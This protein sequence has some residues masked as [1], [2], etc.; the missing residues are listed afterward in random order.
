[1]PLAYDIEAYF[2][3][4][5]PRIESEPYSAPETAGGLSN[6]NTSVGFVFDCSDDRSYRLLIDLLNKGYEVR[7]ARRAFEN[8]GVVYN[9]GSF[10]V[11][12]NDNPDLDVEEL[13]QLAEDAGVEVDGIETSLGNKLADLGGGEFAL[14]ERPRIA[15][16][17]GYPVS[18]SS[19][20]AT[21]HLLD[22]RF[23]TRTSLLE[24]AALG[25]ADLDKYNVL[26]LPDNRGGAQSYKT[27]LGKNGLNRLKRWVESGGTLIGIGTGAAFMADSSA[28]LTRVRQKRQSLKKL[29]VFDAALAAARNAEHPEVDSLDVWEGKPESGLEPDAPEVKAPSPEFVILKEKDERARRLFPRGAILTV[30]LDEEHW[31]TTGCRNRVPVLFNSRYALIAGGGIE[32]PGRLAG[33]DHLRLSGLLWPEAKERWAETVYLSREARGRGQ[34]ILFAATPNFRGYFYGAE[35]LLLNALFLGPGFG[36]RQSI[37]W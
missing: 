16:V 20:G 3:P 12:L 27:I 2:T 36:A 23:G 25:R 9:R 34:V 30:D 10:Q 22:E 26:V 33:P 15:L 31:L 8:R 17:G 7:S 11:R 28:A 5:L 14:L 35:R 37:E 32:V 18:T 13:R 6:E 1:M 24:L 21:W 4:S 19:F 29:S